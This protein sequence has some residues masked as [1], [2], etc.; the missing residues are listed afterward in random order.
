MGTK[1]KKKR[2]TTKFTRNR[3]INSQS[4]SEASMQVEDALKK[5]CVLN[6]PL[7]VSHS[8]PA[9]THKMKRNPNGAY[10]AASLIW[11]IGIQKVHQRCVRKI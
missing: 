11:K 9:S 3:E 10:A 8:S 2:S 1:I 5:L 6:K 4:V 7:C